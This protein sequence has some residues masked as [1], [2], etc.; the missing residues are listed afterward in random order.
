MID[1]VIALAF[2]VHSNKGAYALLLGSGISR[3]SGIPTGWEVVLDLIRKLAKLEGQDCE[4]DPATW[5]RLT[6]N[7]EPDY[8][9]LLDLVAKT[10]TE[11]Q[12]L[13]REYF[14]P[15]E[16]E[17]SQGLK[18]PT[19]A[20]KAIARL[21]AA[22]NLRIILTTNFDRLAEKALEE[23]GVTPTVISTA[24]QIA[25]AL[26]LA[27]SGATIIKL[28]GDYLDTRIRNTEA[29][30]TTYEPAFDK[31]LDRILDE[32]GLIVCGWSAEWDVSL[33][34]AIERCPSRRFT[35]S[36]ATRSP[37]AGHAKRLVDHRKAEVL[38][39]RD[40][41]QL[42]EAL[43][44]KVRAL[45]DI[46]APHPLS[47]KIAV[48]AAK[49]HLAD[50]TAH[51]RLRDLVHEETE[52][53]VAELTDQAFP[54]HSSLEA[55]DEL[56]QRLPKYN[57]L[58]EILL[59][60]LVTGCYWGGPQHAKL[61]VDSLQRVAS[62]PQSTSGLVYLNKLRNYPALLLLYGAGLAAVASGNYSNLAAVLLQPKIKNDQGDYKPLPVQVHS[63]SVIETA[64]GRLIPGMDRR[65]T[66]VSDY[67][68]GE[69]RS[70]LRDYTPG[71]EEY[72]S[73]F[74]RFEYLLALVHADLQ[75]WTSRGE[76]WWGP[77]GCFA[78]RV[79]HFQK[80]SIMGAIG[81]EMEAAGANWAP[82][83]AGLFG[84]SLEQARTAKSKFDTFLKTISF[85]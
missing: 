23:A 82:L 9:K 24:D 30:L 2:S 66:P 79:E 43:W 77:I 8:S 32:Y 72:Q 71:D 73:I 53:L 44:E 63:I 65:H 29:E 80:S 37:L 26:P 20:H 31:L 39:I 60:L 69:L 68:L 58:C 33:R 76:G 1:P 85:F 22:G 4:P 61:W 51:I 59:S 57:A 15:S 25:G 83:K 84:G 54:A 64:V 56:K 74:D 55:T 81:E 46:A 5:Y 75:R 19:A 40:A 47:K 45:D 16:D 67:L 11:R 36:W 41:D 21:V 42:F 7:A 70:P 62:S 38:N 78:W 28:H 6:H 18:A 50:P 12:R 49:R 13:L 35:T 14:E 10:P 48:A 3:A 17:R 27:H 52:R 34:A